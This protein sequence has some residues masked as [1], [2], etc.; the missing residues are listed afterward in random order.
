MR[1][2][3]TVA[4]PSSVIVIILADVLNVVV[5]TLALAVQ[6]VAGR[7]TGQQMELHCLRVIWPKGELPP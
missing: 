5:A 6:I 2:P 4:G 7:Y 1:Q 3:V